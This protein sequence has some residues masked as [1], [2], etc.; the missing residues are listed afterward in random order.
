MTNGYGLFASNLND[1]QFTP[2]KHK[3]NSHQSTRQVIARNEAILVRM[4]YFTTL[5]VTKSLTKNNTNQFGLDSSFVRMTKGK[6]LFTH[7][8]NTTIS[9]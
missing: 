7:N 4:S 2:I 6:G 3:T 5:Q 8:L 9:I 1:N